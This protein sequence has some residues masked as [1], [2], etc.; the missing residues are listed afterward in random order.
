MKK[1]IPFL[2]AILMTVAVASHGQNAETPVAH[3]ELLSQHEEVLSKKYLSYI[4]EVAHGHKAR[5]ME[6]RREEVVLAIKEAIRDCGKIKPFKGDVSLRD[7]QKQYYSV[8]LSVF[9][10]DYAKIVDMEEVAERSYDAMEAYLMIQEK[11]GEKL[12]EAYERLRAEHAA[13]AGRN[14]VRLTEAVA[15]KEDK[16]L[17][18]AGKVSNYMNQLYL[19]FFKSSVQETLLLEALKEKDVN[20]L[21]QHRSSLQKFSAEGLLKLDTIKAFNGDGSLINACRKVLEFHK[22]E[23]ET[24]IGKYT[25]FL[26]SQEQFEKAKKTFDSKPASSRTQADVDVY[27]AAVKN[28]NNSVTGFNKMNDEV[29]GAREKVMTHWDNTRQRF[30]HLHVPR[31]G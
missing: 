26:I 2:I 29:N 31:K 15:S 24:K 7:A 1:I 8:L 11:A 23:A 10:E 18:K 3:M 27:N 14:N 17:A 9:T 6:K 21:E 12:D 19:V 28:F 13:F 4:H 30:M 22:N 16:K 5:K 20:A 25:E